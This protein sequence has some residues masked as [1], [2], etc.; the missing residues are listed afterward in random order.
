FLGFDLIVYS[1]HRSIY[2]IINDMEDFV[3]SSN[4][5]LQLVKMGEKG[6]QLLNNNVELHAGIN[7]FLSMTLDN[8][9]PHLEVNM[10]GNL[11][12]KQLIN[13]AYST[14]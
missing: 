3:Y 12:R 11:G 5:Q 9:L 4:G 14:F 6:M 13:H 2:Y 8:A 7:G 10:D 1:P